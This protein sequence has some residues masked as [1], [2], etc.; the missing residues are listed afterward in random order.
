L[1]KHYVLSTLHQ[2]GIRQYNPREMFRTQRK[3]RDFLRES[4][5]IS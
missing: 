2:I 5:S 4:D 3:I 1:N